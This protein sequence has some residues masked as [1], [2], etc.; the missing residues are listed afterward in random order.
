[1]TEKARSEDGGKLGNGDGAGAGGKSKVGDGGVGGK[2]S[3]S[4]CDGGKN[5]GDELRAAGESMRKGAM[6][7]TGWRLAVISALFS[8]G[9]GLG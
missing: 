5:S 6:N 1:M 8:M 7:K 3:G 2:D 9:L 4:G